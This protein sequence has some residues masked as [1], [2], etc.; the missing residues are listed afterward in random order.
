M[1]ETTK[2]PGE[3]LNRESKTSFIIQIHSK[4]KFFLLSWQARSS[5]RKIFPQKN[6]RYDVR[7]V[8]H[9]VCKN[10]TN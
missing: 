3:L 7:E 9:A 1:K 10:C 2:K 6:Q 4:N 5:I 8:F